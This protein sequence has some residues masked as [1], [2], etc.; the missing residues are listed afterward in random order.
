MASSATIVIGCWQCGQFLV[1]VGSSGSRTGAA[2]RE[3]GRTG[4]GGSS[5]LAGG[6]GGGA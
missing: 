1:A 3:V 4:G 6:K 5:I 2:F